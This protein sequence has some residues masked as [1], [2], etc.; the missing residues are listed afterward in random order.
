VSISAPSDRWYA[1][2][3][4]FDMGCWWAAVAEVC[5]LLGVEIVDRGGYA[6]EVEAARRYPNLYRE[7]GLTDA[8][9]SVVARQ[10]GVTPPI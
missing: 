10:I 9:R 6:I 8:M 4:Y 3:S 7:E 2:E 5:E 1:P